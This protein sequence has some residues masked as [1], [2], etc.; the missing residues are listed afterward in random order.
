MKTTC[1]ARIRAACVAGA[2]AA[3]LMPGASA[4]ADDAARTR[5]QQERAACLLG[6]PDSD[7]AACLREA[8]AAFAES[9]RGA[10]DGTPHDYTA[11]AIAGCD[12]LPTED[13]EDCVARV[14]GQGTVSGS[15]EGGGLYR[16]FVR[17]EIGRPKE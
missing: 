16:E 9:R 15:V 4:A 14:R 3:C 6:H 10:L 12:R 5:L 1:P 8:G 17:K 2:I 7:Q 11:N 13:R